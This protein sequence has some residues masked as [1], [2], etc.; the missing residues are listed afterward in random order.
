M[1]GLCEQVFAS[2][3]DPLFSVLLFFHL[4]ADMSCMATLSFS[5]S[6]HQTSYDEFL[7]LVFSFCRHWT[8]DGIC[9]ARDS[10]VKDVDDTAMAFRLLRLHGYNVSPSIET[11]PLFNLNISLTYVYLSANTN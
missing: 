2:A 9:W 10:T 4:K 3:I 8:E 11:I 5:D 6:G 7:W 1:H